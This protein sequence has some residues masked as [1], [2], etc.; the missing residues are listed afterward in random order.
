MC[1]FCGK[2]DGRLKFFFFSGYF[3]WLLFFFLEKF[4]RFVW[5]FFF[6]MFFLCILCICEF[7]GSMCSCFGF[8]QMKTVLCFLYCRVFCFFRNCVSGVFL[9]QFC[10][11]GRFFLTFCVFFLFGGN[12]A[13]VLRMRKMEFRVG[14]VTQLGVGESVLIFVQVEFF[15]RVVFF[16]FYGFGSLFIVFFRLMLNF[17]EFSRVEDEFFGRFII[18]VNGELLSIVWTS[19]FEELEQNKIYLILVFGWRVIEFLTIQK[20]NQGLQGFRLLLGI[21]VII[22]RVGYKFC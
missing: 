3:S 2:K 6:Q 11:F 19:V 9:I 10:S 8:I 22:V 13:V 18:R 16:C 15:F 7:V 5:Q 14:K 20:R 12:R 17:F 1:F 4:M 21:L